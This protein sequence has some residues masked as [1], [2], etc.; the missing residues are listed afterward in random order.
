MI[1][2][3]VKIIFKSTN[4]FGTDSVVRGGL[5]RGDLPLLK[6]KL[7]RLYLLPMLLLE[8]H[9][10]H[11]HV[12]ELIGVAQDT[13]P[14]ATMSRLGRSILSA[15]VRGDLRQRVLFQGSLLGGYL[16]QTELRLLRQHHAAT[17]VNT[18]SH[19]LC[20]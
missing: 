1:L 9:R 15:L 14:L 17:R 6:L 4:H 2:G 19:P 5:A 18:D 7:R 10:I 3:T 16:C 12:K 13:L 20:L 8:V 11:P